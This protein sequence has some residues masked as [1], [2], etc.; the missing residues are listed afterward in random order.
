VKDN[1]HLTGMPTTFG[2]LLARS[3]LPERAD[4]HIPSRLRA[5]GAIPV[6]KTNVPEFTFEGFTANRLWGVTRNPWA[7]DWSP[8]GSSGG[9]GAAMAAGMAPIG[10]GTDGGG[11]VRIPAAFCGFAALKPTGGVIARKPIPAW[12]DLSTFGPMAT[13]MA[14]LR[15]LLALEAGPEPGDPTAL[16]YR[17]DAFAAGERPRFA[18][19]APRLQDHGPLPPGV[20]GAFDRALE[21][22]ERDL[23]LT[24]VPVEPAKIFAGADVNQDWFTLCAAEHLQVLGRE[25][26]RAA[27]EA[28]V[29][30]PNFRAV[31]EDAFSITLEQYLEARRRRFDYVRQLDELLGDPVVLLTPTMC[32]EGFLA[33]GDMP[34]GERPAGSEAY[35]TD[36][37]NV[38]GH[39]ALSVPAGLCPNGVP[40]G[41]QITGPRFRDDMV[42]GVGEALERA[43]P[44]PLVAPSYEP[45]TVA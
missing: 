35:N 8:G 18:Y 44:W 20:Q 13:S 4:S 22:V 16:P 19:A 17:I 11:S 43:N 10:T 5:A 6:G 45:F 23:G 7:T 33:N 2:T 1:E 9:S 36:F 41:L 40:F 25:R 39:P 31:M 38:T 15:L 42:L 29:L 37:Q 30:T 24:I 3:N 28:D 12:I 34:A 14:D 26:I 21:G 32:V 27:I